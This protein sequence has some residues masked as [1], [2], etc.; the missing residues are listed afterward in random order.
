MR[1]LAI[2]H[3]CLIILSCPASAKDLH[4]CNKLESLDIKK[5]EFCLQQRDIQLNKVYSKLYSFHKE[6]PKKLELLKEMQSAWI[7]MRYAQCGFILY[8]KEYDAA[9]ASLICEISLIQKRLQ[10]LESI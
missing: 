3:I 7:Q 10:E 8:S 6:S 5:L 9:R 4:H 1:F 2:I